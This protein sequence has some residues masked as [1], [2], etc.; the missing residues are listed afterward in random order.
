MPTRPPREPPSARPAQ[1]GLSIILAGTGTVLVACASPGE[2]AAERGGAEG[3]LP[4]YE[5][6]DAV[7][8]DADGSIRVR[9]VREIGREHDGGGNEGSEGYAEGAGMPMVVLEAEIVDLYGSRTPE[10]LVVTYLDGDAVDIE[11]SGGGWSAPLRVGDDVI[12]MYDLLG[13]AETPGLDLVEATLVPV[14]GPNGV[15]DVIPGGTVV[16]REST[17]ALL[18]D[19]GTLGAGAGSTTTDGGTS[20][21]LAEVVELAHANNR[22]DG[23]QSDPRGPRAP[24]DGSW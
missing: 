18:D 17:V 7:M 20:F 6:V 9:I 11:D 12:L 16:P 1:F 24:D 2:G 15:M 19:G 21:A 23:P 13:S 8:A 4:Y 14:G 22:D 5:S 3:L 10:T